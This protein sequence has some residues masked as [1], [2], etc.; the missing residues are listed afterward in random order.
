MRYYHSL[1]CVHS[2]LDVPKKKL[3]Q[4]NLFLNNQE[5]PLSTV[6]TYVLATYQRV[7]NVRW[8]HLFRTYGGPLSEDDSV[9]VCR[10][11]YNS[12]L[13]IRTKLINGSIWFGVLSIHTTRAAPALWSSFVG[14]PVSPHPQ[15]LPELLRKLIEGKVTRWVTRD[16]HQQ[17]RRDPF[18]TTST[19][20]HKVGGLTVT[21]RKN[22]CAKRLQA[23]F[24]TSDM[25]CRECPVREIETLMQDIQGKLNI[26]L[27]YF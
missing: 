12:K 26:L 17:V 11:K 2:L 1:E 25:A 7:R 9:F 22:A 10:S 20:T 5:I 6:R 13:Y 3:I 24:S 16:E 14:R 23:T 19:L 4:Y 21:V 18:V 8:Q 27:K 15:V